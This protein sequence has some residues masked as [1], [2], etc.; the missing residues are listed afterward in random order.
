M[1]EE[2]RLRLV[3]PLGG[4][5]ARAAAIGALA[6]L[7]LLAA[8]SGA[9]A[10]TGSGNAGP[11][12][13]HVDEELRGYLAKAEE[14]IA[15]KHYG[16]AIKILQALIQREES[17]FYPEGKSR[18][19]SMRRKAN[20]ALGRMDIEGLRHYRAL[21]DPQAQ[22]LCEQA[23]ASPNPEGLLRQVSERYL[24]TSHGPKSLETLG[25]LFFDAARFSQ[26][27]SC[28]RQL[29][30]VTTEPSGRAALLAKIAAA[31]FL[32]GEHAA[33]GRTAAEV[34][35]KHP[36]AS[37]VLG[38]R[39]QKLEDFLAR[40]W[41]M[42]P[43]EG[44]GGGR[45]IWGGWP[46]LGGLPDP[47]SIMSDCDVVLSPRWR[48]GG[49]PQADKNLS[50]SLWAG[51]SMYLSTPYGGN[52]YVSR[53]TS[54]QE[55][56]LR[57]G[58]LFLSN[59]STS[60]SSSRSGTAEI[61]LPGLVH[62]VVTGEE[63]IVR[64]ENGVEA[65]DLLTGQLN[66]RTVDRLRMVR[67]I[68]V[69]NSSG[70]YSSSY[71][72]IGDG[73]LYSLTEGGGMIFTVCD[74]LPSG[75]NLAYAIQRAGKSLAGLSDGSVLAALSI[76]GQGAL[77]WHIGL[78]EGDHE[79]IANG[80]FL[81]A[82]S[83]R[84][85]RLYAIVLYL[86][87]YHLVCVDATNGGSL[88]WHAQIAQ[89]PAIPQRYGYSLGSD[90][91][92]AL[93]SP[94]AVV[95]GRVYVA[96]NS[97]VVA[98]FEQ[99]TGE[100][101]WGYQYE[102]KL[103]RTTSSSSSRLMGAYQ[104]ANPVI[105]VGRRVICLPADSD[106]LIALD[107]GTGG[108]EWATN[109]Q[110]QRDLTAVD[111][112]RVLMS[113]GGLFV[114]RAVDGAVLNNGAGSKGIVGRPAV[115]SRRILASAVGGV[116]VMDLK[117]YR[118]SRIPLAD[119]KNGLLGNLVS[120]D[121]KLISANML[122]VCAYFGFDAAREQ[123]TRRMEAAGA[124]AKPGLMKRRAE[125]AMD[126]RRYPSALEDLQACEK[127][128]KAAGDAETA[129]QLPVHFYRTYKALGNEA[130]N[131]T[132]MIEMFLKAQSYSR[133][134][135]EHAHMLIRL[136]KYHERIGQI[137]KAAELIQ[138]VVVKY[139]KEE[140]VDVKIGQEAD[141]W[142]RLGPE[143]EWIPAEK[144]AR[145]YVK[146]LLSRHG[147]EWYAKFDAEAK[148][149][150]DAALAGGDPKDILG[151]AQRWPNSKWH[152]EALFRG[153]EALYLLAGE[154][155]SKADDR[156]AE[157]RRQLY[158]VARMDESPLRFSASVALAMIYARGGWLT[159]ARKECEGL[160]G[161]PDDLPVAFADVRGPLSDV[162]KI[163]E[164]GKVPTTSRRMREAA[165]ISPPL[166]ELFK[167]TGHDVNILRDQ[168]HRPVRHGDKIALIKGAEVYLLDPTSR[169]AAE[170]TSAWKGLAGID[171]AA[172]MKNRYGTPG[173][174]LIGGISS[175]G[176]V[177]AVADNK[178]IRGL[179]LVTAKVRWQQKMESI[180][181][182]A[183]HCMG[184]G[185]GVLVA[186]DRAGM[187]SCV[188]LTSGQVTW[189][190]KLAG[191][192]RSA[193]VGPPWIGGGM[194]VIH[195]N[196]GKSVSCFDLARQGRL[197]RK[198]DAAQWAQCEITPDGL[199]VLMLD[200]TVTVR[201]MAK[202][203]KPLWTR[204]YNATDQ[205]ALL[206]VSRDLI[207]VSSHAATG[208]VYVLTVGGGQPVAKLETGLLGGTPG[209]PVDARFGDDGLFV[210]CS[211]GSRGRPKS[212]YGRLSSSRGLNLQ[213]FSLPEGKRQWSRDLADN[214]AYTFSML[215]PLVVGRAHAVVTAKHSM[216]GQ[217][218]YAF[219]VDSE[220]GKIVQKIDMLGK[221][222]ADN[223]ER[224]RRTSIGQPV[225]T[226]G[227][228]CMET[229]E[230]V[231]IYGEK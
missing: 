125:L 149:A 103:L 56:R 38:G 222:G 193:P 95:D 164:T 227:R 76:K 101:V 146:D 75:N 138:Q 131:D 27:A 54:R 7:V 116:E 62:P 66:W 195:N 174:R 96:T 15:S 68:N 158:R 24:H 144:L 22:Q 90:P 11:P 29:L 228:L 206:C 175:D 107:S 185:D 99:E 35:Q 127:L 160:R 178:T 104:P 93:G 208:P 180:G 141:D 86:E 30:T 120:V 148:K 88:V 161:L 46:G 219:V 209:S 181:I 51:S 215:L 124:A 129:N 130:K 25:S 140:L 224:Y 199:L 26:A 183:F 98:A 167:L 150:L 204:K 223:S 136:A 205:P 41:K 31:H 40:V 1:A 65:Y 33:A 132:E 192:S 73:G 134:D 201:E 171:E 110:N 151:V 100:P 147:R 71:R 225:M 121:G 9:V 85:G 87:R 12:L 176:R 18:F 221:A 197:V 194:A 13:L 188:N 21:Y 139:A 36:N 166:T 45:Q 77:Q 196:G 61:A 6:G 157:A 55:V 170:A 115:S 102:S 72:Y 91:R 184:V 214:R 78:G 42:P 128:A 189:Q 80:R 10:Q 79:V 165:S 210:V 44:T 113:G 4:K 230:G 92:L 37:A 19:V 94:P 74:F 220:T 5:C 119:G 156:L 216:S 182:K 17:G 83:Y 172:L 32:A 43:I 57:D 64:L 213:R 122:G 187:V 202:I 84:G 14:L 3:A 203:D 135:Q 137:G 177:L 2:A 152:A 20:D 126:A 111:R 48:Q 133:T 143:R 34:R 112:D 226:N 154:D 229:S 58:Q 67:S 168:E 191:G 190:N 117:T 123:L 81:S 28:W 162:L 198:W 212:G 49:E 145:D 231:S 59:R 109:R 114:I 153:A 52:P 60:S 70:Y 179:D 16:E 97:G 8:A 155:E 108:L 163:I 173:M 106:H 50:S 169:G 159:S 211:M 69:P 82:P 200:G 217:A 118:A 39:E 89:T 47:T 218:Y 186:V 63:V 53:T 207:A 105:V 142:D 23:M